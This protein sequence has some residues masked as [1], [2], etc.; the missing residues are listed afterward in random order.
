MVGVSTSRTAVKRAPRAVAD[1]AYQCLC[2]QTAMAQSRHVHDEFRYTVSKRMVR[3]QHY[4]PKC[5]KPC[6]S[7]NSARQVAMTVPLPHGQPQPQA[8]LPTVCRIYH[9]QKRMRYCADQRSWPQ[10]QP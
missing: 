4:L 8:S 6:K 1:V 2:I 3:T 7:T 9:L 10:A 5:R